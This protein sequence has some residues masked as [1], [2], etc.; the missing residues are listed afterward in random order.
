MKLP[1]GFVTLAAPHAV[2]AG[3]VIAKT[4]ADV[5]GKLVALA[6][7]VLAARRLSP[8]AFGVL[9][10]ATT[11][12]WLL[13][14]ATDAGWSMF[15]AREIARQPSAWRGIARRVLAWRAGSAGL[16]LAVSALAARW[17][18]PAAD[19]PA[20]VLLVSAAL[21]GAVLETA[22]HVF[23]GLERAEVEAGLHA[24]QRGATGLA[25]LAVLWWRPG[26]V[27]LGLAML[28][29]PLAALGAAA[30]V[31]RRLPTAGGGRVAAAPT[32]WADVRRRVLPLG[33][34]A[35]ISALY[36]RIDVFFVESWHGLDAAGAYNAVF[37]LVDA[38]R[39]LPGAV[40]AVAF[41]RLVRAVEPAAAS[42]LGAALAGAGLAVAALVAFP[43][44]WIVTTA[45]GARYAAAGGTLV[46]LSA[47]VPLFYLNYV[48]THQVIAWDGDTAY[49]RVAALALAANLAANVA[50]VPAY[51]ARGAAVATGLTELAVTAG[52]LAALRG[53]RA[54]RAVPVAAG[55]DA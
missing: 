2:P 17:L 28:L 30:A 53:R 1:S 10:V 15:L 43:A 8:E 39:L 40:L 36:F 7:V 6:V 35:L 42:K 45:Y 18:V 12:G 47:S 3:R 9:A 25:G 49:A 33:A 11:S 13:G 38:L 20:F 14:V 27:P 5:L 26:L 23:R 52:C 50:L 55:G 46:V 29:P 19:R 41:P 48:L 22:M 16:G 34:G 54:A 44:T 32:T 21:A 24:A 31:A 4:A 51:G 37:R